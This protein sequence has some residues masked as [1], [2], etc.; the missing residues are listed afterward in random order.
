MTQEQFSQA[1]NTIKPK[2]YFKLNDDGSLTIKEDCDPVE[3]QQIKDLL[4]ND[5][6]IIA[7]SEAQKQAEV[8]SAQEKV[9]AKDPKNASD[10]ADLKQQV[11]N[12]KD[13]ILKL[14][15]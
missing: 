1:M 11:Q 14:N 2:S 5:A 4:G 12:L 9:E 7:K 10:L 8:E 13:L 3:I 15:Q 6:V